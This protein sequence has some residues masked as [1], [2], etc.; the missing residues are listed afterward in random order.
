MQYGDIVPTP[1]AQREPHPGAWEHVLENGRYEVTVSVGRPARRAPRPVAPPPA[2]TAATWCA[3][4]ASRCSRRSRPR[5]R[6]STR[7]ARPRSTSPT[8][9]SPS[10]PSAATT[11]RST[12][13]RSRAPA[14]W[15]PTPRPR[16]PPPVCSASPGNHHRG[17]VVDRPERHRRRGLPRLPRRRHDRGGRPEHQGQQQPGHRHLV[18]RLRADQRH[19]VRLRR[20]R[21]RHRRQRRARSP[22]WSP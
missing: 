14:R 5:Q 21:G 4:R 15:L 19:A 6:P 22:A 8:A 16:V 11:P 3:P 9:A 18:R 2:T 10:T 1:T 20:A 17:P 13:S 12:G 7:P